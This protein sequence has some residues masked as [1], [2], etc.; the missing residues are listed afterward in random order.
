MD[1][2]LYQERAVPLANQK[3]PN[4]LDEVHCIRASVCNGKRYPLQYILLDVLRE[5]LHLM[6]METYRGHKILVFPV[7]REF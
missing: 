5:D 3:H 2:L 4:P 6:D 1:A 7:L